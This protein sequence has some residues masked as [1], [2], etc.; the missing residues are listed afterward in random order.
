MAANPSE[1]PHANSHH[2]RDD[3][4]NSYHM[5]GKSIIAFVYPWV[6]PR[7]SSDAAGAAV[8]WGGDC[9]CEKASKPASGFWFQT[10]QN[11]PAV[12]T[13]PRLPSRTAA[14]PPVAA[15]ASLRLSGVRETERT[16]A[17]KSS[18]G[19]ILARKSRP[20]LFRPAFAKF[21]NFAGAI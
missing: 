17:S 3:D 15:G 2:R 5:Y 8:I 1:I 14:P 11:A 18:S 7:I 9:D 12:W 16:V 19:D 6:W 21:G 10:V 20:S 4:G 13:L